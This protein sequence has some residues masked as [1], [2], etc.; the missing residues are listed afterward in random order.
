MLW[1]D[2]SKIYAKKI[3]TD[4]PDAVAKIKGSKKYASIKG[5]VSFYKTLRG[6]LVVADIA[7]LPV[8]RTK[9]GNTIFAMHIHAGGACTGNKE[10]PF[11]DAGMHFNPNNCP[12]PKHAGDLP[13]LFA[14]NGYAWYAMLTDRFDV[15]DVIGRTVIVHLKPDD[16]TTQPSGNSDG[17]IACGVI[18][19]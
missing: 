8:D 1:N 3:L 2:A 11:A 16:F 9:C 17:K 18:K 6:T 4:R 19:R 13:P 10:D 14:D 12:H 7:G 15:S 5:T